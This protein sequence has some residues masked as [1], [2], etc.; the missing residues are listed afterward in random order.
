M[1]KFT[2]GQQTALI[3]RMCLPYQVSGQPV[4]KTETT[5]VV[6]R[7]P[8]CLYVPSTR[9]IIRLPGSSGL[10][11]VAPEKVWT[12]RAEGSHIL[13]FDIVASGENVYLKDAEITTEHIGSPSDFTAGLRGKNVEFDK[14]PNGYFRYTRITVEI[15]WEFPNG[16]DPFKEENQ[17]KLA[18][19]DAIAAH[20]LVVANYM[21]DIYRVAT[22]DS[23]VKRLSSI[24]VDDIRIGIP[25]ECSI[26]KNE[27]LPPKFS[28]KCG[29]HPYQLSQNGVRPAI[30]T[31]PSEVIES[32]KSWLISGTTPQTYRLLQLNAEDALEHRDTKLAVIE[33]FLALEVYVEQFYYQILATSMATDQIETLLTED[34][35]WRLKT[36]L[37]ELLKLTCSRSISDIDNKLWQDWANGHEKRNEL[38]HRGIVPTLD[39]AHEIL[40]LNQK[41]IRILETL[42]S[43]PG[44]QSPV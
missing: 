30:V 5:Q 32:F 40:G 26:R 33:S 43:P 11:G 7:L 10:I 18:I 12:D 9:Y 24:V 20:T 29:I 31:K 22:G 39:E 41:V 25:D 21:V 38:V 34:H 13:D 35:N 6:A 17:K 8:F 42:K 37:K 27:R 28:Y 44:D 1:D 4:N 36:R 14:D 3:Q 23:Y 16:F 15:D 19:V 2:F